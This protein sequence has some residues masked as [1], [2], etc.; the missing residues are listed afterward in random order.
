[1]HRPPT[2]AT[3]RTATS[4]RG[5]RAY[6]SWDVGVGIRCFRSSVR[7]GQGGSTI[8]TTCRRAMKPRRIALYASMCLAPAVAC[9]QTTEPCCPTAQLE[10]RHHGILVGTA[11]SE[12]GAL[13]DSVA[14]FAKLPASRHGYAYLLS[15]V[16]TGTDGTYRLLITRVVA[17]LPEPLPQLDTITATIS[18]TA[19]KSIDQSASGSAVGKDTAIL[20]TFAAV[21][22]GA[23]A[24]TADVRLAVPRR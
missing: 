7:F 17:T 5:A 8:S 21:E 15:P 1:M 23:P 12:T 11:R 13:L 3:W 9:R 18:F 6:R 4:E 2:P 16:F 10:P 20:L 24:T 22:R 19:F 14:V